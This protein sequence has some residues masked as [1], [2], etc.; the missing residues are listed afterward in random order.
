MKD[1]FI[2]CLQFAHEWL[3]KILQKISLKMIFHKSHS[4]MVSLQY[5]FSYVCFSP[6]C[7]TMWKNRV[8]FCANNFQQTSQLYGFSPVWIALCQNKFPFCIKEFPPTGLTT[9][10]SLSFMNYFVSLLVQIYSNISGHRHH[11]G[12]WLGFHTWNAKTICL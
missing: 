12:I 2:C 8:F 7:D 3:C 9:V 6:V 1:F 5:E 11:T 10:R 4:C